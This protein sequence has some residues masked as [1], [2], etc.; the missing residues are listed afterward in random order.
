M[1][2]DVLITVNG[3]RLEGSEADDIELVMSTYYSKKEV[4]IIFYMKNI[5]RK[6]MRQ[7]NVI[8]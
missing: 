1:T 2:K 7:Q 3:L 4:K 8:L 5:F 6:Q